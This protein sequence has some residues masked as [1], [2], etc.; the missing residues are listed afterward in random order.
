LT[1]T[2]YGVST[3]TADFFRGNPAAVCLLEAEADHEDAWYAR[4]SAL[5]AQPATA[6]CQ[7]AASGFSL[8]W[9]S[10][11][12]ELALCGHGTLATAHVL[13]ETGMIDAGDEVVLHATSGPL[14]VRREGDRSWLS[15]PAVPLI[16]A[17]PPVEVLAAL[18]V[19]GACS[20]GRSADD[21]VVE[22]GSPDE[23]EK[24]RPDFGLLAQLPTTR[25]IVTAAGGDGVDFTSRVFPPRI[26][27]AEDQVTGSAHAALGPYW[28]QRLGR[29]RLTAR[30]ASA[31]G[32]ELALDLRLDGVVQIGGRAVTTVR[33]EL[34]A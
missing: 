15:L 7:P 21:L 20:F 28:A 10:P 3:F 30:Q 31:R 33:G 27:I 12:H 9:F 22:L 17:P 13:Y 1:I 5:T 11:T 23:V 4:V 2:L 34:L 14:P 8:R 29:Q 24:V 18:G 19:T 26:G 25:T 16:D 32:G 6:F